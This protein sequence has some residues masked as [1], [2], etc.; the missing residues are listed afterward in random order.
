MLS[1]GPSTYHLDLP[2][3]MVAVH[4][5]FH[6]SLFKAAKALPAG[7]SALED[8]SHEVEAILQLNNH[9]AHAKIK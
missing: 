7:L 9:G 6:T 1:T 4:P 2:P 3:S 8:D 5:W